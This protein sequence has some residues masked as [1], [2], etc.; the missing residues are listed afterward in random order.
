VTD[1]ILVLNAGSSSIKFTLFA[2]TDPLSR[3]CDGAVESLGHTAH[4]DARDAHGV[5]LVDRDLAGAT[6][7]SALRVLLDWFESAFIGHRLVAVGHRV[8][9]G[10]ASYVAPALVDE[11]VMSGLR[12]LVPLAPLHQPHNLHAIDALAMLHPSLPQVA[13]F[14]TAFHATQP[15]IATMFALPHALTEEGIRRY[16]F[17]GLSYEYIASRLTEVLGP[18]TARG[19]VVVAHLGAGASLCAMLGG[20]SIATTMGFTALDGLVMGSR[21]GTIDPGVILY[22]LDE[23]KM[24]A[25]DVSD[26]LYRRSGLLGV[27]GISDDMRALLASHDPRARTAVDLFVYRIVRELGSLAAALGGLDA[28]IFTAG[29]GEHAPEIRRRVCEGARWLGIELDEAANA[30]GDICISQSRVSVW[31]APTDE[32]LMIARHTTACLKGSATG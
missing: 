23:R 4:F 6:H 18:D 26:L 15:A 28:L 3:L 17:H 16:G 24:S 7:E 13:C 22:L 5:T 20:K 21:T 1:T 19:R 30:R 14:D 12:A 27:S 8:V 9:H 32:D 29:I 31:V 10:G 2:D 25:A 11:T